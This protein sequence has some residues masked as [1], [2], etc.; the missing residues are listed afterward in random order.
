[1]QRRRSGSGNL[2]KESSS[3]RS[4]SEGKVLVD[5]LVLNEDRLQTPSPT[6]HVVKNG[7]NYLPW[8]LSVY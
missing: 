1:M 4:F 2:R 8:I 6:L 7:V 5:Q 3:N